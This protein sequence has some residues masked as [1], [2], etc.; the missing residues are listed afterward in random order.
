MIPENS[1]ELLE[2]PKLMNILAEQAH[3]PATRQT[4]L[5]IRPYGNLPDILQRQRL[6]EELRRLSAEGSPLLIF[7]FADLKPFLEKARPVGAVLDPLEL[8]SFMPLLQ[9]SSAIAGQIREA[10]NVP[11][12]K[13]LTLNL[14]GFPELLAFLEKALDHEGNVLD[15]ASPLLAEL[16]REIRQ[17]EAQIRRKLE[18]VVREPRVASFLQDD[19]ITQRSGRWVIPVRMDSKTQIPGVVHDVSRTGETA[20]VEPLNI[21]S[22]ANQLENLTAEEK[23]EVIRI[24][25]E[26]S[27]LVRQK[28]DEIET[29]QAILVHLDLLS[30]LARLADRLRMETPEVRE[31][32]EIRLIKARHPLLALSFEKKGPQKQVVPL[33]L[34]LGSEST[35]M[36]IT[37]VNAGGKTIALKTTG[38]LLLMAL[39]GMPIPADSSSIF[40]LHDGLLVDIGD[41]Q[42]IESSLSTFSAHIS[43]ITGILNQANEKTLVLMDELGT[44]TDPVEGAAIACAVLKDLQGKGALVMSTTHLTEIKGFVHRTVGM[45]NASMEFDQKTLTPLYQLRMGEPGQSHALEIA[46]QYGLPEPILESAQRLLTGREE[47]FEQLVADLNRKRREYE[48]GLEELKR[49][50]NHLADESLKIE[51]M[52]SETEKRQKEILAKAYQE[53][54]EIAA[55]TKRQMNL[56]LEDIKRTEKATRR[57]A[58]QKLRKEEEALAR[59]LREAKGL[60]EDGPAIESLHEGNLIYIRSLGCDAEV[61][62]VLLKHNRIKVRAEGR[63]IEVPISDVGYKEGKSGL[64][65]KASSSALSFQETTPSRINLIGQR[66]DDAFSLIEPFLNHA[67]LDCLQEVTIVHGIGTGILAR[68]VRDFLKTHPLV[69]AFRKGDRS[70]GGEGV[71][72]ARLE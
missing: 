37:G 15:Q 3:C 60:K 9:L 66:V 4:V 39:S 27:T 30:C 26:L 58:L 56:F 34:E 65:K 12:L 51:G 6:V 41:E 14:K 11:R 35:V 67:S 24:L 59:K 19:F 62:A 55:Q 64:H 36:V 17:L 8:A 52:L 54:V 72:I 42:S 5:A 1:L 47:G 50:Q 71:T 57:L 32:T 7:T 22:L 23:A 40:P 21:I 63:E 70:E 13:H 10:E 20:F 25:R 31:G 49:L 61:L 43:R 29:E 68:A 46:R 45:V 33:T 2:Y 16:R 38:L 48:T 28:A 44:S 18:E 53:A 69:K